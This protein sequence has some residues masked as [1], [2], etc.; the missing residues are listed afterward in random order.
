MKPVRSAVHVCSLS[1]SAVKAIA[2]QALEEAEKGEMITAYRLQWL[3]IAMEF[4]RQRQMQYIMKNLSSKGKSPKFRAI[5][6]NSFWHK[7]K[8][9]V[10]RSDWGTI[11][12]AVDRK[13]IDYDIRDKGNFFSSQRIEL[14]ARNFI[15]LPAVVNTPIDAIVN[16]KAVKPLYAFQTPGAHKPGYFNKGYVYCESNDIT[17]TIS[18]VSDTTID[19][20]AVDTD[21]QPFTEKFKQLAQERGFTR[22]VQFYDDDPKAE[23]V[24]VAS[25]QSRSVPVTDNNL[26]ED[27]DIDEENDEP[28]AN[29]FVDEQPSGEHSPEK[30]AEE[31]KIE[32]DVQKEEETPIKSREIEP[33]VVPEKKEE[34]VSAPKSSSADSMSMIKN[35]IIVALATLLIAVFFLK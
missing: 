22:D 16:I 15:Q 5:R 9:E 4:N 14:A 17:Q 32:E 20:T 24:D 21:D 33:E 25:T 19:S 28:P 7:W 27:I 34:V 2:E 31:G 12:Q 1:V 18:D 26:D 6:M 35:Y 13:M 30:N 3:N 8:R 29:R 23:A 11:R 10:L